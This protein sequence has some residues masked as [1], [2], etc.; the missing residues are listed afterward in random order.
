MRALV[1]S[2]LLQGTACE[3]NPRH[4]KRSKREREK[5]RE[6]DGVKECFVAEPGQ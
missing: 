6:L 3:A 1:S 5:R 4:R 2:A